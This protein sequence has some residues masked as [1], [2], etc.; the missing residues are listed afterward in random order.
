MPG[1][2][3][4]ARRRAN[5]RVAFSSASSMVIGLSSVLCKIGILSG[6]KT[7]TC[8]RQTLMRSLCRYVDGRNNWVFRQWASAIPIFQ[9]QN[10]DYWNG[11]RRVC[12][13]NWIIWQ[14]MG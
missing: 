7:A 14:N 8:N 10:Q 3:N 5:D 6:N 11:W 13:V 4:A 12:M 9:Q 1:L 2:S